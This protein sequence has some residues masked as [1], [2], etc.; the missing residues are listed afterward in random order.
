MSKEFNDELFRTIKLVE[1]TPTYYFHNK[2]FEEAGEV[3]AVLS[4][5]MGSEKKI[6]KL[7]EE[8]VS[9]EEALLD[10][11][12]DTTN[13]IMILAARY[14]MSFDEVVERGRLKMKEKNDWRDDNKS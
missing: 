13:V 8:H 12:G 3:A 14:G 2:L 10:E 7:V 1:N 11:L 4:G 5:I 9:L 6:K